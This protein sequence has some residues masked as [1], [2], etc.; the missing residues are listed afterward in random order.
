[1]SFLEGSEQRSMPC[2]LCV[3]PCLC[4]F[5]ILPTSSDQNDHTLFLRLE[6]AVNCLDKAPASRDL[7]P[8]IST[9]KN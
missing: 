6:W 8:V 9:K 3:I 5:Q 7:S 4:G 1:M 2:F